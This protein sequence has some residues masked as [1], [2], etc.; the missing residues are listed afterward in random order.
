[1]EAFTSVLDKMLY[2]DRKKMGERGFDFLT[3]NYLVENTYNAIM[4]HV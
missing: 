2:S 1:M 3:K 4:S